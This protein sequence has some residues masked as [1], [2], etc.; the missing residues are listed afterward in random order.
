MKKF[1]FG[2]LAVLCICWSCLEVQA[3]EIDVCAAEYDAKDES[4]IT[5]SGIIEDDV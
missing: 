3:R 4:V 1:N 5:T 2:V